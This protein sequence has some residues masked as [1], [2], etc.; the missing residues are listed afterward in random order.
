M[1]PEIE[2]LEKKLSSFSGTKYCVTTSSGT[3]ALLISLMQYG[4]QEGDEVITSPFSWIST[5]EVISLLKAKPVFVDI[6]KDSCNL[7]P[8]LIKK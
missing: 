8:L 4:I 5:A 7:D 2:L 1:G 6:Q 3:D